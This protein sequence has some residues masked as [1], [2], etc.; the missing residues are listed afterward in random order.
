M[1]AP[2]SP[3]LTRR[4]TSIE[5]VRNLQ[6]SSIA[7]IAPRLERILRLDRSIPR[8]QSRTPGSGLFEK[9]RQSKPTRLGQRLREDAQR[10]STIVR[11]PM[12][13]MEEAERIGD[14]FE[15]RR[16]DALG[17]PVDVGKAAGPMFVREGRKLP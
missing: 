12:P 9:R 14:E 10:R 6:D 1:T 2:A 8:P 15:R 3:H 4:G 7:S 11:G 16:P 13:V 5:V 17:S